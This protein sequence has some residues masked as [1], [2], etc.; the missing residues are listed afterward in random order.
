MRAG[1][2]A[3]VH[4]HARVLCVLCVRGVRACRLVCLHACPGVLAR[5]RVRVGDLGGT[6][7]TTLCQMEDVV[8]GVC[9]RIKG[10]GREQERDVEGHEAENQGAT[11]RLGSRALVWLQA[12][13]AST[14]SWEPG[15]GDGV[16]IRRMDDATALTHG[17][18]I[19]HY[20]T[21]FNLF[22][23]EKKVLSRS[24]FQAFILGSSN[25]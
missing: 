7:F 18:A 10:A 24:L 1:V 21:F 9:A 23:L 16:W 3:S 6:F 25:L 20:T 4:D 13:Q 15:L 2:H 22:F 14:T 19:I 17:I 8:S 12:L 5:A 11:H